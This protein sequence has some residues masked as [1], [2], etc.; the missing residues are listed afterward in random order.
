MKQARVGIIGA[1]RMGTVHTQNLV[2]R[3]P[4]AEV[5]QIIDPDIIRAQKLAD[6]FSISYTGTEIGSILENERI[7]T[8]VITSP[9]DTHAEYIKELAKAGKHIFCEKPI[10]LSL[11]VAK[12]ALS[13]VESSGVKFSVA[14][15]RRFDT[16]FSRVMRLVE[17]G[18]IGKPE[19]I[20]ITS[21]DPEPQ[22]VEFVKS[23][24]G[25]LVDM[26]IHD[27]DIARFIMGS[28][29]VEVYSKGNVLIDPEIGKVGDIDTVVTS[30]L[31]ENG[32]LGTINNSRRA[33]Y[34]YDQRMEV[35]GSKGML[36]VKNISPDNFLFYSDSGIIKPL[37]YPYFIDRYREAFY[38]EM[39]H[40]ISALVNEDELPVTGEDGL[41][42]LAIGLAA[43]QSL[44][45]NRPVRI[46]EILN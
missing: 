12:E 23:S 46:D 10:D 37:P 41:K 16:Q 9:T 40:F 42:A 31:F 13:V 38:Q 34:G 1:G 35:F 29:I 7:D 44:K 27:F 18:K 36:E 14:F 8:V 26:V 32:A 43:T 5:I 15:N 24:G 39:N 6:D 11:S 4:E 17:K 19:I 20:A 30:L 21:R 22:I 33:T 45:E 3:I 28:E 2:N 25:M